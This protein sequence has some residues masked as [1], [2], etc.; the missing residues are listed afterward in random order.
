MSGDRVTPGVGWGALHLG[1]SEREAVAVLGGPT[2]IERS[3]DGLV[4]LRYDDAEVSVC[5]G[6][7]D[8]IEL[9]GARLGRLQLVL[10][11]GAR[12]PVPPTL[13]AALAWRAPRVQTQHAA[14]TYLS[15][16][17]LGLV[18]EDATGALSAVVLSAP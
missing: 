16:P 7:V 17:G 9:G 12:V 8:T 1:M 4:V 15:Y 10:L 13:A 14:R 3:P 11:D 6:Q 5:E 2:G 18:Y